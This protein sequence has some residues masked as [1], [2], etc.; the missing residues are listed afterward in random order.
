[1]TAA[2]HVSEALTLFSTFKKV[3]D[4]VVVQTHCLYPDNAVVAVWV[5]GTPEYGF[6]ASDEGRAI[7][8]LTVCNKTIPNVDRFLARFCQRGGLSA[9]KGNIVSSRVGMKGLVSAILFVANA[10]SEA[11]AKGDT[12]K[13]H[14]SRSFR[15]DLE[16]VL[17]DTFPHQ[18]IKRS[19]HRSFRRDLEAV[20]TDTFPHQH[21]KRSVHRQGETSRYYRFDAEIDIGGGYRLLV[22]PVTPDPNSINARHVAHFDFRRRS[23]DRFIQRMVYDDR[24]NWSG[25]DLSLLQ[26]AA[27]IVPYSESRSVLHRFREGNW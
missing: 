23:D 13:S 27:T 2:A 20:L 3:Q 25:A 14:R 6:I 7:D 16:A 4:A 15:R 18:H 21:I 26:T 10:S 17:T 5:R 8:E 12:L 22:D 9:K 24:E 1:M 11:V 19:V